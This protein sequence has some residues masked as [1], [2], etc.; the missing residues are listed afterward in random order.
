MSV[1]SIAAA[2]PR[3]GITAA[4]KLILIGIAN[5]DG[6][7]G[8]WPGMDTL[9]DYAEVTRRQAQKLLRQLVDLGL[10]SVEENAG[11]TARTRGDRRPNLYRLHLDGASSTTSRDGV[12][13]SA[14]RGV[15][16]RADGV[17]STT[18]EPSSNHP[19]PSPPS[20]VAPVL[21][22]DQAFEAFYGKYPRKVGKPAAKRAWKVAI[23]RDGIDAIRAGF[24][25]WV[26]HWADDKIEE[27]FIPHPATWLNQA[28]Y[29]DQPPVGQAGARA[30]WA[31]Q[32]AVSG[33]AFGRVGL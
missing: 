11:G 16:Q 15:V 31:D 32:A 3:R 5:H 20:A 29:N 9:A 26:K 14:P 22:I 10:V 1:E 2:L 27:Q 4:Q 7:G 21:S 19:E 33:A 6:D 12:S 13:S 23:K 24:K 18:P 8:S 28:R 25:A 30:D 17:S